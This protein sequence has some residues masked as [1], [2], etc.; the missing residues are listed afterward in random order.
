MPNQ[1]LSPEENSALQ[2]SSSRTV[3]AALGPTEFVRRPRWLWFVTGWRVQ[4]FAGLAG[5]ALGAGSALGGATISADAASKSS[6]DQRQADRKKE[7]REKIAG[8]YNAYLDAAVK[9]NIAS[10]EYALARMRLSAKQ[11]AHAVASGPAGSST[12]VITGG[13]AGGVLFPKDEPTRVLGR[14]RD[15]AAAAFELAINNLAV[16]GSAAAWNIHKELVPV[17]DNPNSGTNVKIV[18]VNQEEFD[19]LISQFRVVFCQGVAFEE[20]TCSA[21]AAH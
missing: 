21:R 10:D 19:V 7:E 12:S 6:S 1:P 18:L 20:S 5:A 3:G 2:P 9:Y 15:T 8:V 16:Y 13:G 14:E 4:F 11:G 17:L